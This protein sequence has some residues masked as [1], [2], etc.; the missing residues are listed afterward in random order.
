MNKHIIIPLAIMTVAC[1]V[2][3]ESSTETSTLSAPKVDRNAPID[4]ECPKRQNTT[5]IR[6]GDTF[7]S[8]QFPNA[9]W[10]PVN[11][12]TL[13]GN[14][15]MLVV[16]ATEWC[17]SCL[18]EFDYLAMVAPDW[19]TR[20]VEIY[21][22]LFE[23]ASGHPATSNTLIDFEL[24]ML[25]IYGSIPF[26]VLAD[27]SAML[28]RSLGGAVSLPVTWALNREMVVTNF[29]EGTNSTMITEWVDT[30]LTTPRPPASPIF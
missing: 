27:P 23:N 2:P 21:F 9:E 3:R 16:T 8:V 25:D 17:G 22:T 10:E 11:I 13:C 14:S 6:V 30:I 15:A 5:G 20:G 12:K 26:R 7:P 28:P 29:S 18:V 24:Y 1:G 19:K 4:Y